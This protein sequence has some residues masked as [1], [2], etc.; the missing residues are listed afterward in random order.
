MKSRAFRH[1]AILRAVQ[2][3]SNTTPD[4]SEAFSIEFT[5][6]DSSVTDL[7]EFTFADL[8]FGTASASRRIVV[9]AC[10]RDAGTTIDI[11][12]IT[13]GGVAGTQVGTSAINE[14]GGNTTMA[15]MFIADVPTGETGTVVVT[16]NEVSI[17]C[18][19]AVYAL[20]G[21]GSAEASATGASTDAHPTATLTIPAGGGAIG[22]AVTAAN[23]T[24]TPTNMDDDADFVVE[25]ATTVTA[26]SNTTSEGATAMTFTFA[27]ASN[28]AGVFAVWGP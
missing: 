20:K 14:T 17:R 9:I 22:G 24:A 3:H 28:S 7:A 1:N 4:E 10:I 12:G 15:V 13:I 18:G 21:A 27:V 11:T 2:T 26:G 19:I 8:S 6:S 5:D 25:A 16:W 23:T